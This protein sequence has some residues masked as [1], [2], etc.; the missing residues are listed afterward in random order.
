MSDLSDRQA[1]ERVIQFVRV[2]RGLERDGLY[3]AAK[4]FW[5]AAFSTEVRESVRR[6]IPIDPDVREREMNAAISELQAAGARPE[7]IAALEA[8]RRAARENRII[9]RSEIPEVSVCRDCGEIMVG[10]SPPKCPS[11]GARAVTF[12]E[13]LPIHFLE[14]LAPQE[15]LKT[16]HSAADEIAEVIRGLSEAQMAQVPAP[17]RWSIRDALHHLLVAQ[18]LLAGRLDKLLAEEN[19]TLSAL[20]SWMIP[21]PEAVSAGEMLEQFRISRQH[22]VARLLNLP[23]Q[24][25][26]RTGQHEEFGQVTLLHQASY[27]ARHERYHLPRIEATRRQIERQAIAHS[28]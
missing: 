6:G 16:L 20:A 26:F 18:S 7:F 25:W 23:L 14:P 1:E 15:A 12:R 2:A 28:S 9:P 3:N 21:S 8:G 24:A 17:G 10:T 19:P 13:I 5:A 4:L 22:T 11:C 27:F